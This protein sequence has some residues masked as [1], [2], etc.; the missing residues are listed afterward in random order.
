MR[1]SFYQAHYFLDSSYNC[2]LE[3]NGGDLS[4]SYKISWVFFYHSTHVTKPSDQISAI[5]DF[6]TKERL[7]KDLK[8]GYHDPTRKLIK[9]RMT[10]CNNMITLKITS[11]LLI[12][13]VYPS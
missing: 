9:V 13:I 3:R 10:A 1:L 2:H 5:H 12:R 4:F 6:N 11:Q 7:G 8:L